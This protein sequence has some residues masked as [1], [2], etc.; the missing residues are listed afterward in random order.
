MSTS[1]FLLLFS[2]GLTSFG[3]QQA[4]AIF[5]EVGG[6]SKTGFLYNYYDQKSDIA[7]D[8]E[9]YLEGQI[10]NVVLFLENK[11]FNEVFKGYV[12]LNAKNEYE[13]QLSVYQR[14]SDA[15]SKCSATAMSKLSPPERNSTCYEMKDEYTFIRGTYLQNTKFVEKAFDE[16]MDFIH[17]QNMVAMSSFH[18]IS[19]A[20]SDEA[21]RN[22][23]LQISDLLKISEPL[24]KDQLAELI[25]EGN[26]W[27][28]DVSDPIGWN[29][30]HGGRILNKR[31]LKAMTMLKAGIEKLKQDGF[32]YA[33]QYFQCPDGKTGILPK[34]DLAQC[35]G[36]SFWGDEFSFFISRMK[37]NG[38]SYDENTKTW[39]HK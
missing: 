10:K 17:W 16:F 3:Q 32:G 24:L 8:V 21:S 25:L 13:Y 27:L 31:I 22:E 33:S 26:G 6:G 28:R 38:Y 23:Y 15:S 1:V 37:S 35:L 9:D 36:T 39:G 12:T 7:K 2:I 20:A 19:S 5:D 34:K 4:L 18:F 11:N 30:S 14:K 29:K